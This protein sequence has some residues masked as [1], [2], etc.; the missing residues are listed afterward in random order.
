[1]RDAESC[2][3]VGQGG[4]DPFFEPHLV[5]RSLATVTEQGIGRHLERNFSHTVF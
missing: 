3:D 5:E 2:L 1:M 4:Y